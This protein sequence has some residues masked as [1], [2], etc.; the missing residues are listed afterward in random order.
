MKN[1]IAW[2][3]LLF[4]IVACICLF[5]AETRPETETKVVKAQKFELIDKEGKVRAALSVKDDGEPSLSLIDSDGTTRAE[6]FL[7]DGCPVLAIRDKVGKTRAALTASPAGN[8]GLVL[9]DKDE[10]ERASFGLDF[11]GSPKMEIRDKAGNKTK[12][13]LPPSEK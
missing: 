8:A 10:K 7:V 11:D 2:V 4:C 9:L 5:A 12:V 6:V 13:L 3:A 1:R